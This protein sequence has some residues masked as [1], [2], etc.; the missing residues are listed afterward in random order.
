MCAVEKAASY[1][2]ELEPGIQGLEEKW[3]GLHGADSPYIGHEGVRGQRGRGQEGTGMLRPRGK[4][5]WE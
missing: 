2:D 5:W 3:G 1:C 4:W